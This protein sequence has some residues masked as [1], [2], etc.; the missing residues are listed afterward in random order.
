MHSR[1]EHGSVDGATARNNNKR[2]QGSTNRGSHQQG[3]C[4]CHPANCIACCCDFIAPY[5]LSNNFQQPLPIEIAL[6]KKTIYIYILYMYN[7][8]YIYTICIYIY[9]YI[10][11]VEVIQTV[12]HYIPWNKQSRVCALT[13]EYVFYCTSLFA[14]CPWPQA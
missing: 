13:P 10:Y 5:Y 14:T 2:T 7:N 11:I 9:V 1:I 12:L 8:I 4:W 6:G 3:P